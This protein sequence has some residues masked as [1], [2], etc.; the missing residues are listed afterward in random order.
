MSTLERAIAIAA[1]AHA[2]QLDKAGAPYV[3]HPLRMMLR[4]EDRSAQIAAVLH[5]V[6]EDSSWTLADL[7]REGF[8][9]EVVR[10][11]DALTRRQD[12]AYEEFVRRSGADPIGWH[13]KLVDLED[14]MNTA[15]IASPTAGDDERLARYARALAV[16]YELRHR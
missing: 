6:V 14:N 3:L 9:P 16:L 2:G 13:V 11:V 15:R 4:L 8:A 7:E 10:A 1:E 12:E 5:D